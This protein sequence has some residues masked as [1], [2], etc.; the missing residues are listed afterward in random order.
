MKINVDYGMVM[1]PMNKIKQ[2]EHIL[3]FILI[4][5]RLLF[6]D[7]YMLTILEKYLIMNILSFHVKIKGNVVV[8]II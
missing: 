4:R 6:I 1:S 8:F 3:I 2:K 7:Y 5:K